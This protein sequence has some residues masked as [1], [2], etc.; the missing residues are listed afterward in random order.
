MDKIL[1]D[2]TVLTKA[3]FWRTTCKNCG[4]EMDKSII[5]NGGKFCKKGCRIE[6]IRKPKKRKFYPEIK[7]PDLD[8]D[9][10]WDAHKHEI[11]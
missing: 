6:F 4:I 10:S 5:M 3:K 11:N 2:G 7:E 8:D 9:M 1:K